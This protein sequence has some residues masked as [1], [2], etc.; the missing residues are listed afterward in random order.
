VA[1]TGGE[2]QT[3]DC[4]KEIMNLYILRHGIAVE[5]GTRGFENDADRPLTLKGE[6]RVRAIAKAM[7]AMELSFDLLLTSPFVRARKTAEL[8]AD[9]F[10]LR[11]KLQNSEHLTPDGDPK[12][13]VAELNRLDADDVLLSG[14]EPWLSTFVATL[15]CDEP[16]ASVQLKKGGLCKLSVETLKHGRCATLE[17]LLTPKQML[18]MAGET[19]ET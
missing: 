13:L 7:Q 19:G 3:Q 8:V 2:C 11:E 10:K 4:N 12:K 6:E 17:W 15:V 1:G 9:K 5:R 14:H 18:L 16:A